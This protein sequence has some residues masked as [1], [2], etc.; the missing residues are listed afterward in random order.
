[1]SKQPKDITAMDQQHADV[2]AESQLKAKLQEVVSPW[3]CWT[4]QRAGDIS[5]KESVAIVLL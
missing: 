2:S 5:G 1:M 3:L 4:Q